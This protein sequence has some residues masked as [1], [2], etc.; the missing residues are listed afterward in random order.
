MVGG[1]F[2]KKNILNNL[3][4]PLRKKKVKGFLLVAKRYIRRFLHSQA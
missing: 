3:K 2:E 4:S 1:T